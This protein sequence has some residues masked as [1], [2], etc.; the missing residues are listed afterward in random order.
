MR[1]HL[2]A[3]GT[4]SGQTT[5]EVSRDWGGVATGGDDIT[6]VVALGTAGKPLPV[7]QPEPHRWQV[8]HAPKE[9]LAVTWTIVP[10]THQGDPSPQT[11]RRP[12]LNQDLFHTYGELALLW[13][14]HLE[15]RPKRDVALAWEGFEPDWK[16]I[17]SFGVGTE[18]HRFQASL[19]EL[20]Q[21][22]YMAGDLEIASRDVKGHPVYVARAGHEWR[23]TLDELADPIGRIV[24]VER[25]FFSDWD[26]PYYLVSAIPIGRCDTGSRSVGG[27]GLTQSFSL[28]M[29]P[30]TELQGHGL[31]IRGLLAHE[32]F[33][34]WNG[35]TIEPEEPEQL[36]YWWTEGFT[37]FYTRRMLLRGGLIT[38]QEYIDATN[39]KLRE[40]WQSPVRSASN[41]RIRIDFWQD[42][43]VQRLPYARGDAVAMLLDGA[44]RRKSKGAAS[45]DDL[46]RDLV[47]EARE[48]GERFTTD[49][50]LRRIEDRTD[51]V[52]AGLV[53]G[54][55]V[56][57]ELPQLEP[58]PFAPCLDVVTE[59]LAGFELGFDF[60]A[61]RASKVVTGVVAG[62]AAANAGLKDGQELSRWSVSSGDVTK[63][64]V[65]TVVDGT[66]QRAIQYLPL[67]AKLPTPQFHPP[68]TGLP[69][70]CKAF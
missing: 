37:E 7:E 18:T 9:L 52:T 41:D 65:M 54:V 63:P 17:S 20:R 64:V 12:I 68:S 40:L 45:L 46:M 61:S 35:Q 14:S 15:G 51:A 55:V 22:V 59:E 58:S 36:V 26:V 70:D 53:R 48:S 66:E 43:D 19:L 11:H 34:E 8:R 44:I 27:T 31:G 29:L 13:P 42:R 60:D 56:S 39:S 5:F 28:A 69:P 6:G 62:S 30:D 24:A 33:H 47:R 1:L 2:E 57:G 25:G 21:A 4:S 38:P 10:N 3:A 50:L 16:V 23:F 32:M 49:E 67:G